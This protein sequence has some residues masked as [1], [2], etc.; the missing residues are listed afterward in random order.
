LALVTGLQIDALPARRGLPLFT[1]VSDGSE[2]EPMLT[3]FITGSSKV[4]AANEFEDK[5]EFILD[6]DLL[7]TTPALTASSNDSKSGSDISITYPVPMHLDPPD[8]ASADLEMPGKGTGDV[9]M[10]DED[11]DLNELDAWLNSGAVEIV[12]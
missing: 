4:E 10:D 7:P 3:D 9:A 6:C 5:E 12:G 8:M 1:Y 11:D 2:D